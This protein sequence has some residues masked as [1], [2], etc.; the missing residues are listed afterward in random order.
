MEHGFE[1]IL[2]ANGLIWEKKGMVESQRSPVVNS[3]GKDF[4]TIPKG[5]GDIFQAKNIDTGE[6]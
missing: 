2:K 1:W 4:V 5:S 6:T 3:G